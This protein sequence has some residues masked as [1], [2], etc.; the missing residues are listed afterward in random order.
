MGQLVPLP[1]K[2][3]GHIL[4]SWDKDLAYHKF[5]GLGRGRG[6]FAHEHMFHLSVCLDLNLLS[7]QNFLVNPCSLNYYKFMQF[8]LL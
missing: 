5:E 7:N 1:W 4:K 6:Q 8:K 2:V 3:M